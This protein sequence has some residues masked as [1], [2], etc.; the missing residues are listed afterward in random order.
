MFSRGAILGPLVFWIL[1]EL[2]GAWARSPPLRPFL[3]REAARVFA[4]I[5]LCC[6]CFSPFVMFAAAHARRPAPWSRGGRPG[7]SR[8]PWEE[9]LPRKPLE[10]G[11]L[12]PPCL[13]RFFPGV[14]VGV[15]GAPKRRCCANG[16]FRAAVPF[17]TDRPLRSSHTHFFPGSSLSLWETRSLYPSLAGP[18]GPRLDS[19][20]QCPFRFF[21]FVVLLCSSVFQRRFAYVFACLLGFSLPRMLGKHALL[22]RFGLRNPFSGANFCFWCLVA[23]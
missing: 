21:F 5:L 22:L 10:G 3:G 16:P 7:W 23:L 9:W 8:P 2:C 20:T 6:F 11:G 12:A 17:Y 18:W 14:C 15:A 4:S 1:S 19:E 13:D